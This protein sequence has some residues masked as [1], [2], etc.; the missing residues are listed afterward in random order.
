[1]FCENCGNRYSDGENFCIKCGGALNGT[2][3]ATGKISRIKDDE[4]WWHRLAKV[5]YVAVHLPL[6]LVVP[7]VWSEN[8]RHYSSYYKE[9]MGSDSDAFWYCIL[10]IIV[11]LVVLRLIKMAV[12]YVAGGVKPRFKD[13]LQF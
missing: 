11:W 5:V 3:A 4:R 10:T 9:Y 6:L 13:L 1:M 12:R 8:A 2:V 7:I